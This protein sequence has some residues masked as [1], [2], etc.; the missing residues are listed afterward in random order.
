MDSL[1]DGRALTGAI[2]L[3]QRWASLLMTQSPFDS[4]EVTDLNQDPAGIFGCMIEGFV[5]ATPGMGPASS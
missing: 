2:S 1:A 3:S 4:V 5:K